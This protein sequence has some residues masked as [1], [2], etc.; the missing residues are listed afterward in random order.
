MSRCVFANEAVSWPKDLIHS[1]RERPEFLDIIFESDGKDVSG[2]FG[3]HFKTYQAFM[4]KKSGMG[5]D[6]L[7]ISLK[8]MIEGGLTVF[9]L[10][11]EDYPERLATTADPPL[12]LFHLG[13]LFELDDCI[14]ISG[15]RTPSPQVAQLTRVI[16]KELC[17]KGHI[18]VSGL[19]EG[20]D[21]AAHNGA[22]E[23]PAGRT[24][25][26]MANGLQKVYPLS[27][28]DL[29]ERIVRRGCLL[30]ERILDPEPKKYDFIRRN[31]IISGLSKAHIIMES[32]GSGGTRHQFDLAHEQGRSIFIYNGPG[33]PRTSSDAAAKMILEGGKPFTDIRELFEGL[34]KILK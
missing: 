14:A 6:E 32:T 8:R 34:E 19:A 27:N 25:A 26:V 29:A 33:L 10:G 31:R 9:C 4:K 16:A 30:S 20:V 28:T 2:L 23:H 15:T 17:A 5:E 21:T 13:S 12:A 18:V 1:V 7:L 22:L 11:S 3:K 24:I